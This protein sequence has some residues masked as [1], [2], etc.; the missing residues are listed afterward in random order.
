MPVWLRSLRSASHARWAAGGGAAA[1]LARHC[2][3]GSTSP[4][5][6]PTPP[7]ACRKQALERTAE[8]GAAIDQYEIEGPDRAEFLMDLAEFQLATVG[9]A[10]LGW[11]L[12]WAAELGC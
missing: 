10:G 11:L 9:G 2:C 8:A 6:P 1:G 7:R 5:H 12:S 4:L 3:R